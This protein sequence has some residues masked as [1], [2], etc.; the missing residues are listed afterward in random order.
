MKRP[1]S[2]YK[3]NWNTQEQSTVNVVK[4]QSTVTVV[5]EQST[6]TVVKEQSTETVVT[7]KVDLIS[8]LAL[9]KR[10]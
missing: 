6:I 8:G 4:K 5:K 3:A 10:L 7:I 2:Y 9:N 1:W